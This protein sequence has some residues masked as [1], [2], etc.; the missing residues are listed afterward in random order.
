MA[1]IENPTN[2]LT[3]DPYTTFLQYEKNENLGNQGYVGKAK[4]QKQLSYSLSLSSQ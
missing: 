2:R 1:L 4:I 3:R